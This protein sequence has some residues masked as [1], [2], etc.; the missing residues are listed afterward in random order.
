MKKHILTLSV[1]LLTVFGSFQDAHAMGGARKLAQSFFHAQVAKA[2]G[3]RSTH[4]KNVAKED[5]LIGGILVASAYEAYLLLTTIIKDSSKPHQR[6]CYDESVEQTLREFPLMKE[7]EQRR[8]QSLGVNIISTNL[9]EQ[10]RSLYTEKELAP[11]VKR[12]T[13][14][15]PIMTTREDHN[16]DLLPER[17]LEEIEKQ[18]TVTFSSNGSTITLGKQHRYDITSTFLEELEKYLT[19]VRDASDALEVQVQK[20]VLGLEG[21]TQ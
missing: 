12:N 9:K 8:A 3:L 16:F 19:Q 5:I 6:G 17:I 13:L 18:G 10:I 21:V 1:V 11:Y 4:F 7:F 15:F 20:Q 2:Q 14:G